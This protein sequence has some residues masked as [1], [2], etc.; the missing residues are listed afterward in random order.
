MSPNSFKSTEDILGDKQLHKESWAIEG[1]NPSN[2][3]FICSF[4]REETRGDLP[5][6]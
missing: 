3:T 6:P 5:V 1:Q 2:R 4:V